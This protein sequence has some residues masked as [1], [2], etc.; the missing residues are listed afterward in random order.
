M[1]NFPCNKKDTAKESLTPLQYLLERISFADLL[2][3]D[4]FLDQWFQISVA[5]Q[6]QKLK[7]DG[8]AKQNQ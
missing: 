7:C 4:Y 5:I 2:L 8:N 3:F 6:F 1:K